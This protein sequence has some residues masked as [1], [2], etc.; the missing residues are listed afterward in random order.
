MRACECHDSIL[1]L[2]VEL[3]AFHTPYT[4]KRKDTIST[5]HSSGS[6]RGTDS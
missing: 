2:S 4:N 6:P 3:R 5:G 1:V